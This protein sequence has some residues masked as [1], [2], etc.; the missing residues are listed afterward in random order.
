VI[1]MDFHQLLY[2]KAIAESKTMSDAAHKLHISQPSLSRALR[3]IEEETGVQLFDRKGR[4]LVL[5]DA[6]KIALR[7]A[8][9]ALNALD[10]VSLE[11]ALYQQKKEHV[12][13]LYAPVPMGNNETI[14]MEFK[15]LHPSVLL[16]VSDSKK[17]K[18]TEEVP[19]LIFFASP[20]HHQGAGYTLLGQEEITLAV[21]KN[22]PYAEKGSI[23]LAEVAKEPFILNPVGSLRNIV[24]GMFQEVGIQPHLYMENQSY[25]QIMELVSRGVGVTLAPAV[26]WF[27]DAQ[28]GVV[29]L[30]LTDVRRTR[31]LYLRVPE[32]ASTS[33]KV[34]ALKDFLVE[35]YAKA[36]APYAG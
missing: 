18:Y 12:V 34:D 16:R 5:N 26:T 25:V 22:S 2:F 17:T 31:Y 7:C 20:N 13:T 14:L 4:S 15:K 19:H 36:C 29:P 8:N 1:G 9:T 6:G 24:D 11:V 35:Y 10:R 32:N 27:N 28:T 3:Q 23:T 30:R 33:P 21:P